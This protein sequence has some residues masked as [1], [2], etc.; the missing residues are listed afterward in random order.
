MM[1]DGQD[2]AFTR[3]ARFVVEAEQRRDQQAR[4]VAEL[5]DGPEATAFA[6]RLLDE[7]EVTL[8][9]ARL[10]LNYLQDDSGPPAGAPQ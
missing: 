7:M 1:A 2:D 9:L 8:R 5:R 3:A 4:V 6:K 10:Y